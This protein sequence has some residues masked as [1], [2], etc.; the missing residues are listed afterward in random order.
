V[1]QDFLCFDLLLA[2]D[3]DNL[4]HMTALC[5]PAHRHKLQLFLQH[6]H[7]AS[8]QEIPDP[9]F[10]TAAGF[11]RVLHLCEIGAGALAERLRP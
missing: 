3:N 1:A 4:A 7:T 11:E 9:Y 5:P 2:M 6:A 8:A 10:G